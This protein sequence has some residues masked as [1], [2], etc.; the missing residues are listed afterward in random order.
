MGRGNPDETTSERLKIAKQQMLSE[1][2]RHMYWVQDA[3]VL[4]DEQQPRGLRRTKE[5]TASVS[6]MPLPGETLD[7]RKARES[8]KARRSSVAGMRPENVVV[9]SLG[10]G[11]GGSDEV[12]AEQ[13]TDGY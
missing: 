13:F 2:I 11:A 5:V 6:V 9:T 8:A 12:F 1:I 3:V 10:D 4:Y 7:P